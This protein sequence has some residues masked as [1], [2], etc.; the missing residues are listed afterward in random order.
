MEEA[1]TIG[2]ILEGCV[3]AQKTFPNG[4]LVNVTTIKPGAMIGP[5]AVFSADHK[6]PCDIIS[7]E[8][9]SIMM[10]KKEDMIALMQ[11]NKHILQNYLI[12]IASATFM[13]QQRLE[14][15]SYS[16]IA[17]KA[18]FYLL[19]QERKTGT[20][21]IIIPGNFSKWSLSMNV[22]RTSLH[23]EIKRME[24]SGIILYAPP[25]IEILDI[26]ALHNILG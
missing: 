18:A 7:L 22:S 12:E 5:A 25:E 26:E 13:L 16:G 2:I 4:S 6:Y 11:M 19:T 9:T 23:R 20:N 3:Q 8:T 15:F 21:H 14:L 17:Q 24:N 10:F 1:D